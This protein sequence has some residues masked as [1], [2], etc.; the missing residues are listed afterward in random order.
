M[1][2]GFASEN[3][4]AIQVWDNFGSVS[5]SSTQRAVSLPDDCA[6]IQY[7]KTGSSSAAVRVYLPTSIPEGKTLTI[8]NQHFGTL[9]GQN[10][11]VWFADADSASS[12]YYTVTP[13]MTLILCYSR[14]AA[15]NT[16]NAF[17]K[18]GWFAI[19]QV[20][21]NA[22]NNYS[23]VVGGDSNSILGPKS[24]IIG[25]TTNS[26]SSLVSNAGILAGTSNSIGTSASNSAIAGG[27]SNTASAGNTFIGG[28]STNTASGQHAFVGGGF[29]NAA[30]AFASAVV[31]GY[32]G[33]ARAVEGRL[34]FPC[35]ANPIALA[36][37]VSQQSF[38]IVGKQTTDATATVLVSN[39]SVASATNQ[40]AL[41]N[42]SAF[43]VRGSCIA[44]VTAGG[45]TKAWTFDVVIK[46][47]ANAAA[48]SIVGAVTK[49][50]VAADTGAAAWDISITADTT[51]GGLAVTATGSAATT[52]RWV[53]K[54][55][56]TEVSF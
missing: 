45:D 9:T 15:Y 11:N 6:P 25:G 3:T 54:L 14:A 20:G 50:I 18:T 30:N 40:L 16:A 39:A 17:I 53:C 8:I 4:P 23:A 24:A 42:N 44:N 56:S 13:G 38:L 5:S 10:L 19:N 34:V 48:T 55:D 1:F 49:N 12:T 52:I 47:G 21:F 43:L 33:T 31:G 28:G 32:W 35:S 37:G 46:R 7:F 27:S 41:A 22:T 26:C 51:N 36:A 29:N 2:T